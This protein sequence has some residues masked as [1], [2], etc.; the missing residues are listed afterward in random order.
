MLTDNLGQNVPNFGWF[1]F[2]HLLGRFNGARQAAMLQLA[3]DKGLE[4]LQ[5][6]FLRQST[7]MQS[8]CWASHNHRSTRVINALTQ[9]VLT[10]AT[11][12]TFNHICQRLQWPLVRS[13]DRTSTTTVV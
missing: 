9:E 10:E 8:Q 4:E 2:Y 12:L 3:E 7:L 11:L 5:S 6:H 1:T 13:S